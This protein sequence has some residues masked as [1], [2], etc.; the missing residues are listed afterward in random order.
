MGAGRT[1][2]V[3][4]LMG[5]RPAAAGEVRVRGRL[6]PKGTVQARIAAGLA[7]VPEDRQRDGLVQ[8]MS[9]GDNILLATLGRL[10]RGG[11]LRGD[12]EQRTAAGKI[13]ELAIKVPGLSA[14][15]T[16]L[17][18]GNQQKVVLARA[19]LTE[20]VVLLLDEP[21]RGIDVGAKAQIAALMADLA[22]QGFG[23]LF[24]SSELAEVTAMADR[25]LVMARG[26]I[27][28]EF[29]AAD[30]TEEALVTASASDSVL[31][32]RS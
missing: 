31:E 8:T 29:S 11:L 20:P 23:V 1:E 26:R 28:A 16:A 17:S 27:T 30:V 3:E 10:T 19:L 6:E 13:G 32:A 7:L 5:M 12:A 18:G 24:I 4:S 22:A 21:T 25:V 9:V 15:V 14:V 2:L